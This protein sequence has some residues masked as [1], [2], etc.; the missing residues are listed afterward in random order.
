MCAS[1]GRGASGAAFM[2]RTLATLAGFLVVSSKTLKVE[3]YMSGLSSNTLARV[4]VAAQ[5]R[6]WRCWWR[7]RRARRAAAQAGATTPA[8]RR[9]CSRWGAG[10][11]W[12]TPAR[13]RSWRPAR[14]HGALR[15][16]AHPVA[17]RG[18][19][20]WFLLV[21]WGIGVPRTGMSATCGHLQLPSK[22]TLLTETWS[23]RAC[24]GAQVHVAASEC[25][26][27]SAQLETDLPGAPVSLMAVLLRQQQPYIK[28]RKL[29]F[30][31]S[32]CAT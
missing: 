10:S 16:S 13:W 32:S 8:A 27:M 2:V 19:P 12:P 30:S 7:T 15:S 29:P 14:R 31:R 11:C 3:G 22:Q 1:L 17:R 18:Q 24:L 25:G 21:A 9:G 28:C 26:V 4:R 20:A 23:E 6:R 5:A